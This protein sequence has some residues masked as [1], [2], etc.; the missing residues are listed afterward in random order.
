MRKQ[1]LT[2][3]L[4]IAASLFVGTNAW[5]DEVFGTTSDGYLAAKSTSITMYDGGTL[6]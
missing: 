2:K 4:L 3:M 6:L 1:L 5:A